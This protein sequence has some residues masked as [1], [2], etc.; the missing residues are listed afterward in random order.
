MVNKYPPTVND[1]K[2]RREEVPRSEIKFYEIL[3]A[4]G[5]DWYAWH[6]VNWDRSTREGSGEV[7]YLIFNP[8]LGFVVIEVKGGII[9]V[10]RSRF[11]STTTTTNKKYRIQD[12]FT[13][14]QASMFHILEVYQ[15]R[16]LIQSNPSE[17]L[18]DNKKFP[19]NFAIGVFFPDC[20]FKQDFETLQY[21]FDRI[22]DE[23]DLFKQLEWQR[24]GKQGKSPLELFL[25]NLLEK[26]VRLRV[27]KPKVAKFFPKLIGSNIS[28]EIS[29]KKYFEIREL[30]LEQVNKLQDYLINSLSEKK[31]CIFKG[32]AG[33]GKTYIAMKK[34]LANHAKEKTTLFLCFNSEL[35]DSVKT[36]VSK[37]LGKPYEQIKDSIEVYSLHQFLS[38][39][40]GTISDKQIKRELYSSMSSFSYDQI[41]EQIKKQSENFSPD[42][43]Y[44]SILIDEA[45]DLDPSLWDVFSIFLRNQDNSIFYVFYDEDQALFVKKFTPEAFGMDA[46]NDLIVLKK[47]LRNSVEIANWLKLK[48]KLGTYDEFSGI[49]GFKISTH[50]FDSPLNALKKAIL[51]IQ[52]KYY[53]QGILA[54]QVAI[55]SYYK[56]NT[57]IPEAETFN[58]FS[59]LRFKGRE[60]E[61]NFCLVEPKRIDELEQL[62]S[63]HDMID[64][65][66]IL[67]KTITSFKGL[68][69]NI[70]FLLMPKLDEFKKVHPD[71]LD[72]FIMQLYVGAS[73]AKFKL[74]F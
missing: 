20:Q 58:K 71:R 62:K 6:S 41:A 7:D 34:A 5:D 53:A 74:Y 66:C 15:E 65:D 8:E 31:R 54:K 68:E 59:M 27:P 67:F 50:E 73:R 28:R 24:D 35:R 30:E 29:L 43:K 17:L 22:F 48:T 42:F 60:S 16:A 2:G 70:L 57:L 26:Y 61:K 33:S 3:D 52:T 21:S 69:K 46:K 18:K 38:K 23:D 64:N 19:L 40:I 9:S 49:N 25:R 55:L 10:D 32:S 45:Q 63:K 1:L 72:N 12:P 56:L 14:A 39:L 47:N 44:D 51:E 36:Y 37:K 4:L 13:Q 11:Y